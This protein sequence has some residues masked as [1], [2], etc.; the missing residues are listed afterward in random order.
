MEIRNVPI[1]A[2]HVP[3][4]R[5]RALQQDRV[6]ILAESIKA[7]GLRIPLTVTQGDF[8]DEDGDTVEGPIIVA[9][10]HRFYAYRKVH[11]DEAR[12]PC[13]FMGENKEAWEIDENY[14]RADLTQLERGQ[15]AERHG[16]L[17]KALP[18]EP[19]ISSE[20]PTKKE[21][22]GR[23]ATTSKTAKATGQSRQHTSAQK[24]RARKIAPDV[25]DDIDPKTSGVEL[26]AL[27]L[28]NDDE[29]R[30]AVER[31]KSGADK[32]VP[33]TKRYRAAYDFIKGL[34][35]EEAR[36]E[37][38]IKKMKSAVLGNLVAI[39]EFDDWYMENREEWLS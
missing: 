27:G 18:K 30:Q 25:Q 5:Q 36:R 33:K 23:K 1:D 16:E 2:I 34:D 26:D 39:K 29:Q 13:I 20:N 11:G 3:A 17:L 7:L 31:V 38:G 22:R 8:I 24:S 19:V 9:G 12:I 21:T 37:E 6:D 4:G 15:H 32:D 10:I 14:A 28:L 35:P